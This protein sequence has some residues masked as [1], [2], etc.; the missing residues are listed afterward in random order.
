MFWV[1]IRPEGG[2]YLGV[3]D[4]GATISIVAKKMLPCG[5]LTIT[6]TTVAIR[7]GDRHVVHSCGDCEGEVPMGSRTIAHGCYVMDTEA[8]DFVL[9][10]D[11]FLQNSQI[12]SL[13]LQAPYLLYVDHGNGRKSVPLEQSRYT[14]SYLRV[15]KEEP[16]NM[17]SASKTEYYQ[18]LGEV[19][20]QGLKELGY[21]REDLSVEFFASDKQH[22]FNLYCSRG[23]NCCYKFY[24]PSF[25][26]AYGNPSFSE[27]G[28]VLTKVALE[29]SRMVLC[30][31]DWGAH[32]GNE[33]WRTLLDRLT[34]SSVRLPDE[35]IYEPL[36]AKTLIGKPGWG[37]MLSVVDRGLTSIPWE[38]LDS[39]LVQTIQRESDGLTLGDLKH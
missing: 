23:K 32:G 8:F 19:L 7:M 26:M 6:M 5:S 36:G 2:E 25:G 20:D 30:S 24:W 1:R 37:S 16:L 27:L 35:A 29:R 15:S 18:L 22:V 17:M 14:S 9:G 34:I 4:T 3:L 11:F 21:S 39:T 38:D 13:T 12:Q 10:T 28:K 31:P 33:Y